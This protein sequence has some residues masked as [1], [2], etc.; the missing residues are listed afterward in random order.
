MG[1]KWP[2]LPAGELRPKGGPMR[3]N[4]LID[5]VQNGLMDPPCSLADHGMA[6]LIEDTRGD[7]RIGD[8]VD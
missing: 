5:G 6:E 4:P 1:A 8:V 7:V 3:D 2:V